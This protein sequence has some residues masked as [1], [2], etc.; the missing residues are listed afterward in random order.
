M[1]NFLHTNV[2][3]ILYMKDSRLFIYA[4]YVSK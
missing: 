2:K 4:K 1:K 3:E